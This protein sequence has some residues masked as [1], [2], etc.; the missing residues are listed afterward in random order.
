MS[1]SHSSLNNITLDEKNMYAGL[2]C[3]LDKQGVPDKYDIDIDGDGIPNL[4]GL[5]QYEKADCSLIPGENVNHNIY[6]QHF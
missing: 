3:D 1:S 2:K 6:Q 5:I 4:L